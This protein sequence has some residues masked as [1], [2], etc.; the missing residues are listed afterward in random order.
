MPTNEDIDRARRDDLLELAVDRGS[1]PWQVGALL[2]LD[3]PLDPAEVRRALAERVRA[4][5][6]LRRRLV[7]TPPLCG[8]PVWVDDPWFAVERHVR[9]VR[10]PGPVDDAAQHDA[11]LY[12][13]AVRAVG[14]RL[15]LRHP[16][17]EAVVVTGPAP[18]RGALV[19]VFHHVL[20]D[21]IGG[22]AVLTRLVDGAP[23]AEDAGFPR[24]RPAA[25]ALFAD[26]LGERARGMRHPGR[27]VRRFREAL[28]ELR[29]AHAP[30]APRCSL[31]RPT[32]SRR[33]LR[34]VRTDLAAV[35]DVAHRHGGTVNDVVLTVVGGA[36][37]TL[38]RRRGESVGHVVASVP[39][40]AR[41]QADAARPG[42][43]VGVLPVPLPTSGPA[44]DRLTEVARRTAGRRATPPAASAPLLDAVF[45]L[46]AASGAL[47][48]LLDHQRLVTT[49][50]TNLRGPQAPLSLLGVPIRE[51]VPVTTTT[52]NVPV[53]FGALSYA[54]ALTL[55]VVADPDAC[56][57]LDVLA[58]D[59]GTD[60]AAL[61][62]PAHHGAAIPAPGDHR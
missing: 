10:C 48:W 40:S 60:L 14:T 49:F 39:I 6:R 44:V 5:P 52:G 58:D 24:G 43:A 21:G 46:L 25:W 36:L 20:A 28:G 22:L 61:L 38:L 34:V 13:I 62:G 57:E 42:N 18:G 41:R 3:R 27:A 30:R 35:R 16:P 47:P 56:P 54:G 4:V 31:H 29:S 11:A 15:S 9:E 23:R 59:L 17:W 26:A 55:T 53:V 50:V 19:M 12:D 37:G 8:R 33:A 1:A 7:R 2:V 32:G 51:I 45:R